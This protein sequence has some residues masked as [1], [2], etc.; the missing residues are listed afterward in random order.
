MM[1]LGFLSGYFLGIY[2]LEWDHTS[3]LV[4]SIIIGSGTVIGETI[5]LVLRMSKM[6]ESKEFQ[7][8][9]M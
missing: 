2:G 8:A 1:F 6:E 5:L 4:L 9:Q 3:S 7:T